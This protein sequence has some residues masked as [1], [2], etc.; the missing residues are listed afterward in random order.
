MALDQSFARSVS[1]KSLA[2]WTAAGASFERALQKLLGQAHGEVQTGRPPTKVVKK[3]LDQ[4]LQ[5]MKHSGLPGEVRESGGR[6]HEVTIC[7]PEAVDDTVSFVLVSGSING[8]NGAINLTRRR[9][10]T[11][12]Q[13][14]L[15]R[16][17]QRLGTRDSLAVLREVFSCL[18]AAV[19]M[20]EAAQVAGAR[21]WPLV[22]TNGLFVCAPTEGDEATVLVTWMRLDQLGKKWGRVADDLRAAGSESSRLLED[23]DFCVELL[24]LHSWLLRPHEPGPDVAAMW[25]ASRPLSEQD[26]AARE[27]ENSLAAQDVD[28]AM[29]IDEEP[30][31][32]SSSTEVESR[33]A[34]LVSDGA[35][36]PHVVKARERYTGIVVQVRSTGARIVALR[37]GFFGVLRHGDRAAEGSA[38]ESTAAVHL[39]ARVTVEVL[40]VV[41]DYYTGPQSIVLQLP[42][43]AD[44][45]WSA[46]QQRHAVG[47]MV[48]GA[49]VWRG[50][51][52]SV[53]A[54]PDGASGWLPDSELSWSKDD[55]ALREP[56]AV[57]QQLRV[58]VVGYADQYRRL[59]L[60]L[61][62]AEG[63]PVDWS[64]VEARYPV[65]AIVE[66]SIV[67]RGSR[68]F[69]I[70]ISET[71]MSEGVSGW[72]PDSEISW[73]TGD[74]TIHRSLVV[75]QQIRLQVMGY[76]Q[77]DRRILLSLR[78]VEGPPVDWSIIEARYPI[79][80]VVEGSVVWRGTGSSIVA[81]PDG[82]SGWLSDGELSWSQADRSARESLAVGQSCRLRVIGYAP[83]RR[84]LV[85]SLRQVEEHP[86]DRVDES[87]FVGTTQRGVVANVVDY[88]AFVRLPIG[89]D[90]LLHKS[91]LPA[92]LALSKGDV[93]EVQVMTMDKQRRR[94][95]LRY[96]DA[97]P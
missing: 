26:E 31:S 15:E 62:Q 10:L 29:L 39:G 30:D 95:G 13:H 33:D 8:R 6:R 93:V 87:V 89:V 37:D 12:S 41:G 75:G 97:T 24:R 58:Q 94:V 11:A 34:L 86:L 46:A 68:G 2:D 5:L 53:L 44:A 4:L 35:G 14:V 60:S 42:D 28:S 70:G 9:V 64:I 56:L 25:W 96:V 76:S 92:D 16:L 57:G 27:L 48:N 21:H 81:I 63:P 85:L 32:A 84:T 7:M 19:A 54:M 78:Q 91:D 55:Q 72:L 80:S 49:I 1:R 43:V 79:G 18:G 77:E 90:G 82:T 88:G 40:R 23:R 83:E 17:H 69:V 22:T 71:A 59:L 73:S 74:R 67:W 45:L 66:G 52:G 61:R 38:G 20:D 36:R 65:G 50:G 3:A 51:G 47:S